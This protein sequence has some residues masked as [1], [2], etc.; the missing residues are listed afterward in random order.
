[1]KH[2]K[3]FPLV[4][5]ALTALASGSLYAENWKVG[6]KWAYQ[7]QGPRPYSDGSATVKGDRTMELTAIRGDGDQKRYLLRNTW[8]TEDANPSTS[9]IDAK[10]MIRKIEIQDMGVLAFEPP[11]PVFW[12]L[13]VGE[14]KDLTTQVDFVGFALAIEYKAKRLADESLTVPAGAFKDCWHVQVVSTMRSDMMPATSSKMDYW[15]HPSVKNFVKEVIVTNYQ[16]DNGYTA[17][18]V[19]KSHTKK[20]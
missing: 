4:L 17:T 20:N 2:H 12:S 18:S 7:H 3:R 16:G 5:I 6:E 10:N 14:E 1:M 19:L 11:V 13:N 9:H 15:Y 8:G